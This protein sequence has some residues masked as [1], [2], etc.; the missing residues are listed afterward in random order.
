MWMVVMMRYRREGNVVVCFVSMQ[1][2]LGVY[3]L[4]MNRIMFQ[5]LGRS[6]SAI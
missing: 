1:F 4:F 6:V 3:V 5:A 2:L